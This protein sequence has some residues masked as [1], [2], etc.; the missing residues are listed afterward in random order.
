LLCVNIFPDCLVKVVDKWCA[1]HYSSIINRG[2][3][4][5]FTQVLADLD[6]MQAGR[7]DDLADA[8]AEADRAYGEFCKI[9]ENYDLGWIGYS[10]VLEAERIWH[11]K[12]G[13][14]AKA[15]EAL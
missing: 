8:K 6:D 5:N 1:M 11:E 3:R 13:E 15:R 7:R 9:C 10:D 4:M 2:S 12:L 14:L